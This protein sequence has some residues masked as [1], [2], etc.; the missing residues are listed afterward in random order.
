MKAFEKFENSGYNSEE[1]LI[2]LIIKE[3]TKETYYKDLN[4][5]LMSLEKKYYLVISYFAARLMYYLNKYAEKENKYFLK[6]DRLYR[7][8]TCSFSAIYLIKGP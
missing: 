6:K 2:K 7:G 5:W 4:R 1:E 3:Y 8:I